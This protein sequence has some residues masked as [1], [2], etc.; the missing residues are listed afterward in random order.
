MKRCLFL[1]IVVFVLSSC[2]SWLDVKP[3]DRISEDAT[4]ATERGF[5]MALNGVY[6]ELN[7]DALYGRNLSYEFVEILAQRYDI[8]GDADTWEQTMLFNYTSTAVESKIANIWETAYHLIANINLILKNCEEHRDVLSDAYYNLIKGECLALR[9]YLHFDIFRLFGPVYSTAVGT[10]NET[11]PYYEEF[12]L[13]VGESLSAENFMSTVIKDLNDAASYLIDDPI[14]TQGVQNANDANS[15]YGWRV[16][17]MNYYAV[18]LLQARAYLYMGDK[19]AAL[20]AAKE[21]IAVKE[22]KFPWVEQSSIL[23][24]LDNPDRVFSTEIVFA[25]QNSERNT[26][27]TS[28]FDSENLKRSSML[29]PLDNVISYMFE[30]MTRDFR[31]SAYMSQ[32]FSEGGSSYKAITKYKSLDADTLYNQ[33][34]PMLR[35]SEA[36]YIAAECET[37]ETAAKNYLNAVLN[38]RNLQNM[39]SYQTVEGVLDLEYYREFWL[40]GQLFFYYKRKNYDEIYSATE[41]GGVVA[42]SNSNYVLPIPESETQYN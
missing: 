11:L 9:A 3:N 24:S 10:A 1:L 15:F 8:D 7:D 39:Y 28:N 38:A 6:I 16:L 34:I 35:V 31:Y 29:A 2:E 36:Y 17:R 23:S 12:Q 18:K 40:E 26:I 13:Y 32:T 25:L 41:A 21:V 27:F 33:M 19:P 30:N 37:D 14:L 5:E 22:E 20:E 4:F 42:V